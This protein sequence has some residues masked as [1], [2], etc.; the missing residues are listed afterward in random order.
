MRQFREKHVIGVGAQQIVYQAFQWCGMAGHF[1]VDIN[2]VYA[3][4]KLLPG[5]HNG[6]L[7]MIDRQT[8]AEYV[9]FCNKNDDEFTRMLRFFIFL[10]QHGFG[11]AGVCGG[12]ARV[13]VVVFALN[14]NVV[15]RAVCIFGENI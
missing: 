11:S 13:R 5:F 10:P 4:A 6:A 2:D 9:V 7:N 3:V 8:G 12:A 1:V 15:V 14:F